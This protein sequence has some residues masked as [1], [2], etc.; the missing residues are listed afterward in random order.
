MPVVSLAS[1]AWPTAISRSFSAA[2]ADGEA[3]VVGERM[4]G[5]ER[6]RHEAAAQQASATAAA[7]SG[8]PKSTRRKLV[9]DG[10]TRQPTARS[11]SAS[12]ARSRVDPLEVRLRGSS[13]SRRASVTS[14]DRDRRHRPGRAERVEPR[15]HLGSR[16][17]E[18]D[19]QAGERVGLA[20]GA[21]DDEVR[22]GGRGARAAR[23]DELGI[24]LV[25]DDDRRPRGRRRAASAASASAAPRSRRRARRAPVGL[26]GLH[27][28]TSGGASSR[29]AARIAPQVEGVAGVGAEPRDGDHDGAA[30]LG[31]DPVHRV[32]RDRDD[33]ARRRPAG[34][35]CRR[36]RGSRPRRRRRGSRR[37]RRRS[38]AA[39]ASTS[40]R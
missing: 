34:T 22:V 38:A 5:A 33:R 13:G 12:R 2:V 31:Q 11:A 6:P 30:L 15:D 35:P 27:S 39:A 14:G 3:E 20:R 23:A 10:P 24:G 4:A 29:A 32:G 40:R 36:C 16:D 19:A 7:R 9:T 17:S 21:D 37:G 25:E 8:D 18:P 28:Q 26:F 1:L